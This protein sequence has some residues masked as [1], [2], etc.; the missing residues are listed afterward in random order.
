VV[1]GNRFIYIR[2]RVKDLPMATSL[3]AL[4]EA[5]KATREQIVEYLDCEFSVGRVRG[6]STLWEIQ[7]STLP[8]REG[9]HLDFVEEISVSDWGAGLLP[10]A[11][12][13]DE[14]TVSMN[15]L[16]PR[17]IKALFGR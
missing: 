9:H 8:W 11:V 4:I 5:T 16:S 12:G 15:T 3:A 2:N 10:R 7:Q 6:G 13:N 14:W 17:D 1:V